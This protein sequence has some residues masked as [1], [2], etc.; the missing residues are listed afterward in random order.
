MAKYAISKGVEFNPLSQI[1]TAYDIGKD[2][3]ANYPGVL[4]EAKERLKDYVFGNAPEL[5]IYNS[6]ADKKLLK[7]L[8]NK[9]FHFSS[10]Y[11]RTGMFPEWKGKYR[12]RTIYSDVKIFG[13]K[14]PLH[15]RKFNSRPLIFKNNLLEQ[16]EKAL[17]KQDNTIVKTPR[18]FQIK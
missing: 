18:F 17:I 4:K 2:K 8:R 1:E 15:Y 12:A 11:G 7:E 14:K 9:Y 16:Q 10:D 6:E 3:N 5:T 13:T